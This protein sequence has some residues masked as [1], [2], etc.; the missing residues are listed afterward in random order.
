MSEPF[1]EENSP[2]EAPAMPSHRRRRSPQ[3]DGLGG[4]F[5]AALLIMAGV[6]F[7][8]DNVG[9]LP[10]YG[11]AG[12][13]DWLMLGAGGLLLVDALIRTLLP[14]VRPPE[15]FWVV[16]GVVLLA[17][18]SSAIFGLR[19]T[20]WWPAILIFIGVASLARALRR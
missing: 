20:Q 7:L 18:S 17:L 11:S 3:R 6:V 14:D 9:M 15:P 1:P 4:V 19:L 8:A 13:W 10:R 5:W 12:V 16:V 2:D